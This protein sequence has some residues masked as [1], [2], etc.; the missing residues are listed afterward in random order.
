MT[1]RL[2]TIV[3]PWSWND[4]PD[5]VRRYACAFRGEFDVSDLRSCIPYAGP[6]RACL[7]R[8]TA[9]RDSSGFHRFID[10]RPWL[11]RWEPRDRSIICSFTADLLHAAYALGGRCCYDGSD[12]A[13]GGFRPEIGVVWV[14]LLDGGVG[15]EVRLDEHQTTNRVMASERTTIRGTAAMRA[16]TRALGFDHLPRRLPGEDGRPDFDAIDRWV[17]E[18][19]AH[20]RPPTTAVSST[21]KHTLP[22]RRPRRR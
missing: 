2:A 14:A 20:A 19:I 6:V 3:R 18:R 5:P 21:E 17:A 7:R 8:S 16:I 4:Q 9:G 22:P 13:P 15:V 10:L 1:P 12:G 11:D